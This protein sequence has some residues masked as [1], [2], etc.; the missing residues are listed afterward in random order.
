MKN[1]PPVSR[2]VFPRTVLGKAE[3]LVVVLL[4]AMISVMTMLPLGVHDTM[5][6]A[7][8][9]AGAEARTSTLTD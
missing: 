2:T 1:A 7:S 6:V 5:D 8:A 3:V 4:V 9:G